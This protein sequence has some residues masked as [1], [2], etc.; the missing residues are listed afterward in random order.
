MFNAM[1]LFLKK[2][3]FDF[4]RI[5]ILAIKFLSGSWGIM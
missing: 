3:W 2:G 1:H 5:E 4:S